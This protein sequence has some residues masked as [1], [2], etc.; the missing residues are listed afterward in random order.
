MQRKMAYISYD[1][2]WKSE[3]PKIASAKERK[4]NTYLHQI[5]LKIK[6][7]CKKSENITTDFELSTDEDVVK[8]TY[9]GTKLVGVNWHV[10]FIKKFSEFKIED[11]KSPPGLIGLAVKANIQRLYD[12]GFF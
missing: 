7:A 12:E 8:K 10:S 4:Q 5:K 2:L 9:V 1:K 6:E 11:R 3:F